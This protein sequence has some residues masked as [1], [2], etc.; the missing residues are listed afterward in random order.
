M[1][2]RPPRSTRTDPL[3]P[4]TT[5][6]R[7]FVAHP[8]ALR[9]RRR[10]TRARQSQTRQRNAA[11]AKAVALRRQH[12]G[13]AQFILFLMQKY[14]AILHARKGEAPAVALACDAPFGPA[15]QRAAERRG[16]RET[17]LSGAVGDEPHRERK[18]VVEGKG[19]SVGGDL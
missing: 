6:F 2:P 18:S 10:P 5:L 3:F 4:Y 16:P 12:A 7:S 9:V 13:Q 14:A 11:G 19:G 17:P 1:I 8:Q 15:R